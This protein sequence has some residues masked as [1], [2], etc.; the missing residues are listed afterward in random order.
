VALQTD[1]EEKGRAGR[2]K[3]LLVVVRMDEIA[4][5][6]QNSI[7]KVSVWRPAKVTA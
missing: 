3:S 1:E 5:I 6:G 2:E 7:P 4:N